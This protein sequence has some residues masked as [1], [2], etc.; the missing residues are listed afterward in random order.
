MGAESYRIGDEIALSNVSEKGRRL[1]GPPP[2]KFRGTLNAD[3]TIVFTNGLGQKHYAH[4][5]KVAKAPKRV[6]G[7]PR[8]MEPQQTVTGID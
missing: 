8:R 4:Y 1:I 3:D 7:E 2:Y 5:A 6:L